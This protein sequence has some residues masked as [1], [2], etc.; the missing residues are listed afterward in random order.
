MVSHNGTTLMWQTSNHVLG[1]LHL[2]DCRPNLPMINFFDPLSY[3]HLTLCIIQ[4]LMSCLWYTVCIRVQLPRAV[5]MNKHAAMDGFRSY[6]Y[7]I[8]VACDPLLRMMLML[9]Q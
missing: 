6:I 7:I 1:F 4:S 8:G 3:Q 9:G 2:T 5:P